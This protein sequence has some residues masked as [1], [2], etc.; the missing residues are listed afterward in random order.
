MRGSG[1]QPSVCFLTL[2]G[3]G[4]GG[5]YYGA[6][7][8]V[9]ISGGAVTATGKDGGQDVGKGNA[10]SGSLTVT[11]GSLNMATGAYAANWAS[12]GACFRATVNGQPTEAKFAPVGVAV[13]GTD[14]A[15]GS[16]TGWAYAGNILSLTSAGP[17]VLSGTNTAGAV[18]VVADGVTTKVTV[19]NLVL[20]AMES[21]ASAFSLANGADVTLTLA[22]TNRLAGGTGGAGLQTPGER[23][24][25]SRARARSWISAAAPSPLPPS[26]GREPWRTAT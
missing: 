24:S 5:C 23:R 15:W 20:E 12:N 22:G 2:C 3:A 21:G 26:R 10:S 8:T 18:R 16:G 17:Y 19:S 1:S 13:D 7:G 25:R 4:I 6:S 11:G 9:T 14:A